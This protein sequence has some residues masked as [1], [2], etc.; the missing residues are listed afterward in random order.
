QN[1][2]ASEPVEVSSD[3]PSGLQD[4]FVLSKLVQSRKPISGLVVSIGVSGP[5]QDPRSIPDSVH[6]LIRSLMGPDDFG[7]QSGEGE[8]LLIYPRELG[9]GAQ[10]KLAIIAER[11]WDFQLRSMSS[12]S[13]LFSWGGV[14]VNGTSISDAI[15]SATE[16]MHET[17]RNRKPAGVSNSAQAEIVSDASQRVAV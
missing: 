16:R 10:R 9:A 15:S 2:P 4:G 7:C 13:I 1:S 5:N 17:A 3:L 12:L 6:Q 11:L 8:F 14:E